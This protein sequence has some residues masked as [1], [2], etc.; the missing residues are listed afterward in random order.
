MY[1]CEHWFNVLFVCTN[2]TMR[3]WNIHHMCYNT[4]SVIFNWKDELIGSQRGKLYN[5]QKHAFSYD[6]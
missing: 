4:A 5:Q 2:C 6:D 3:I 1:V